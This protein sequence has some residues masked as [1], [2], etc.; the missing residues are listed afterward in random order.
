MIS[1]VIQPVRING[2]S[3]MAFGDN[4]CGNGPFLNGG[5]IY[6]VFLDVDATPVSVEVWKSSDNGVSWTEQD[7]GNHPTTSSTNT[8]GHFLMASRSGTELVAIYPGAPANQASF[9]TFD[10]ATDTWGAQVTGGP[11]LDLSVATRSI[12]KWIHILKRLDGSY[13]VIH[14]IATR[15]FVLATVYDGAWGAPVTL[16]NNAISIHIRAV[17]G[18]SDRVHVFFRRGIDSDL[19]HVSFSSADV[20]SAIT[21][22]DAGH[23]IN[24]NVGLP[25]IIAGVIWVSYPRNLIWPGDLNSFWD[26]IWFGTANDEEAPTWTVDIVT[27]HDQDTWV[28][29]QGEASS[30]FAS[31]VDLGAAD[32]YLIWAGP[33]NFCYNI[34]ANMYDDGDAAWQERNELPYSTLNDTNVPRPGRVFDPQARFLDA[35]L[36]IGMFVRTGD[37]SFT[38]D[39]SLMNPYFMRLLT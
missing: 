12:L 32:K 3:R 33:F 2:S 19:Y 9:S 8:F 35:S 7:S 31:L 36:G 23:F 29:G 20:A 37:Y 22:I 11:A 17:L 6:G 1:S 21:L 27:Y 15:D 26:N 39:E 28:T 16:D 25:V 34:Y 4:V 38:H 13:V 18:A 5:D 10:M 30:M 14:N 24:Q